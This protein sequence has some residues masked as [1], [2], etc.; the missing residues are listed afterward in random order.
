M[1]K[2]S[3]LAVMKKLPQDSVKIVVTRTAGS[4]LSPSW[5]LLN[6]YKDG[7]IDWD[8]YVDR[9]KHEMNNDRCIAEMRK[10]KWMSKNR[11]IFLI[12]YE[13]SGNCHRHILK[14]MIEELDE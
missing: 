4:V 13:K 3:Y 5:D 2:E 14:R 12:C 9:F 7:K 6:D 10:I 8:G 1:L 11:D